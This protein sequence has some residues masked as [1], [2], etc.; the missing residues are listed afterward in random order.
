MI[1]DSL[2]LVGTTVAEKYQVVGVVG[3]RGFAVVYRDRYADDP[4]K[5]S[6]GYGFRCVSE[7]L[8][9]QKASP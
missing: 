7:P 5:R 9:R 4:E 2:G 8:D 3:E 1:D 6:Y